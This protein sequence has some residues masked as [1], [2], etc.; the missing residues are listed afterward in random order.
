MGEKVV[1]GAGLVVVVVIRGEGVRR[2]L[3]EMCRRWAYW[4]GGRVS[5]GVTPEAL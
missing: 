2:R 3:C 5:R 1:V 4:G